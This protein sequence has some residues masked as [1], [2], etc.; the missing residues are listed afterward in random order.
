MTY[1]SINYYLFVVLALFFYYIIPVDKRWI[2]ILVGN[3]GFYM[4]FLKTG[5][6]IFLSTIIISY[7]ISIVLSYVNERVKNIVLVIGL[8]AIILPWFLIKNCNF[9]LIIPVGISFY[10]LQIISYII[11]V[12]KN[13][14]TVEKNITKYMLFVSFFPQIIQGPIP[15][16]SQLRNQLV[17]GHLFDEN[18]FTKGFCYI[19]WGFFL[20][21]VIADKS[22]VIVNDIF[23]NYTVYCGFYI[24]IASF[25]YSI[26]LYTDFLACTTLAQGVSLLFGIELINNFNCPYFAISIKDFWRRLNCT[27]CQGH[28]EF[29]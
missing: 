26:Q 19:I 3:I 10:T 15:R 24:W 16:Y 11:D 6:W 12:Y 9:G 25:L 28:F 13:N 2:V 22:A 27:P 4:L 21:L 1:I 29:D 17:E 20:K 5:W 7:F 8:V 18:K 14:I 23:D